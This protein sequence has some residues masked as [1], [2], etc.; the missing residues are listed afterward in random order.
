[1]QENKKWSDSFQTEDS[2]TR[3]HS[4]SLRKAELFREIVDST[5]LN[6]WKGKDISLE[7]FLTSFLWL[8]AVVSQHLIPFAF[9]DISPVNF[10]NRLLNSCL[11]FYVSFLN[12]NVGTRDI[13]CSMGRKLNHTYHNLE[14]LS[15]K[16]E[17]IKI[18]E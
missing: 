16:A 2:W 7:S 15:E 1:M 9:L 3:H 5:S 11:M 12:F 10:E 13:G 8:N 6:R 17:I 14:S 4:Q 18:L